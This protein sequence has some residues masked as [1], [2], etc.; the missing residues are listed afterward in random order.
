MEVERAVAIAGA[1]S[2]LDSVEI[3]EAEFAQLLGPRPNVAGG[4]LSMLCQGGK[5]IFAPIGRGL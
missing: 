4:S 5:A 3:N 1:C 2:P